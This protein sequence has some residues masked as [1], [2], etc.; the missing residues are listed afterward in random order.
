MTTATEN[1]DI[2]CIDD[3][4]P[5]MSTVTGS[6]AIKQ[7]I[8]RRIITPRGGLWYSSGYGFDV[9]RLLNAAM[10]NA[11]VWKIKNA[12]YAQAIAEERVKR[13]TVQVEW[14][15]RTSSLRVFL[16]LVTDLGPVSMTMTIDQLSV[17]LLEVES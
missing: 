12:I 14:H 16:S 17:S 10:S 2:D 3:L 13:A 6:N 7:A 9:R 8:A 4:T 15:S 5:D 11:S 1:V